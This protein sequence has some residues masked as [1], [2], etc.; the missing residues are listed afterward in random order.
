MKRATTTLT[1]TAIRAGDPNRRLPVTFTEPQY[2]NSRSLKVIA[3]E[4]G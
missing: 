2:G 3:L 1:L 4:D